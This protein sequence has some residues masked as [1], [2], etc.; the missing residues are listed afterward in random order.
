M[1]Q[2]IFAVATVVAP[3]SDE[4]FVA[5]VE[6]M[7]PHQLTEELVEKWG[8]ASV[9]LE[10]KRLEKERLAVIAAKE[11]V[12]AEAKKAEDRVKAKEG[13]ARMEANIRRREQEAF[14]KKIGPKAV[15]AL[16]RLKECLKNGWYRQAVP[17]YYD[18]KNKSQKA[19]LP[20]EL[21]SKVREAFDRYD[22]RK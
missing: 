22:G 18:F 1:T 16:G 6:A 21:Q 14:A 10:A 19:E 15:E 3:V 17:A 20:P 13:I 7:E 11:A 12:D 2:S 8:Q 9:R 5:H 4:A